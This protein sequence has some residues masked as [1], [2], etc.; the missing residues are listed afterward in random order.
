MEIFSKKL[1]E[2]YSPDVEQN[3]CLRVSSENQ[4]LTKSEKINTDKVLK[5]QSLS[6][7]LRKYDLASIDTH[8][9]TSCSRCYKVNVTVKN[10]QSPAS[11]LFIFVFSNTHY[12]YYNK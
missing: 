5:L 7:C 1:A 4:I 8:S 12:N 2:I 10:G 3:F 6:V 11:F 9:L